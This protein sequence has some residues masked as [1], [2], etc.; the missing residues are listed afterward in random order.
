[1]PTWL[2]PSL[3]WLLVFVP[4]AVILKFTVSNLPAAVFIAA[5]LAI[6]PLAG[7]L[8]HATEELASR[9]NEGVGGLLNA[10]FGN[11]AELII[12]LMAL[13]Q[14]LHDVVKASLTGSIIGN[15]LLVMGASFLAGGLK[16]KIQTFNPIAARSQANMLT[17]AAIALIVP[18]AYHY[19]G[20]QEAPLLERGMSL[21]IAGILLVTY[22]LGLLFSLRTHRHL[23]TS[24]S[25]VHPDGPH[26]PGWSLRTALVVLTGSTALIGWISEIL[27]GA[28]EPAAEA[29]GM[30]GVFVGVIVVAIIG[31][32]AEHSSAVV[33]A[34]KNRTDLSIGISLGSST[35]IALF[36]APVLVLASLVVGPRPMNLVF[37]LPEVLAVALAVAISA[38]VTMDGESNWLEGVQLLSVYAILGIVF[39]FL[40]HA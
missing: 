4:V 33:A 23:F 30:T 21:E 2:K 18:A 26:G 8:G 11:A 10:T 17:L 15:I 25:H 29:M 38:Q 37:T 13:Q 34:L 39:Y 27:V 6:I 28:V 14:G 35:Q 1:M 36:V 40:P 20:G 24:G 3:N 22:V 19:L 9:T 12:A 31:N 5:C 16:F 32:A 7:L